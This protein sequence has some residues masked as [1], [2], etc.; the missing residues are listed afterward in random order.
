MCFIYD[1]LKLTPFDDFFREV[2]EL[3]MASYKRSIYLGICKYPPSPEGWETEDCSFGEFVE[4]TI[5]ELHPD[6]M[7]VVSDFLT[8]ANTSIL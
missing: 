1:E 7:D 6:Y 2:V 4:E 5:P 3:I 8:I